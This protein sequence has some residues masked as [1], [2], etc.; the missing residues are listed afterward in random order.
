MG[1]NNVIDQKRAESMSAPY[2]GGAF[3]QRQGSMRNRTRDRARR[4]QS[5]ALRTPQQSA[6][7]SGGIERQ[8]L[9]LNYAIAGML[10][11][12]SLMLMLLLGRMLK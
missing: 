7:Q 5:G 11:L 3:E 1:I 4:Q 8:L 10:A 9:L 6:P 2:G 12:N